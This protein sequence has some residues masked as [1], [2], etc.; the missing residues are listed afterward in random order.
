MIQIIGLEKIPII[1]QKDNLVKIILSSLEQ[2]KLKIQDKDI[3]I[4]AQTIISR[5]E[6]RV[7]NLNDITPTQEASKIANSINNSKDPR[8]ITLI[9]KEAKAVLRTAVIEKVGKIIV[10]TNLGFICADAGI[11]ASNTPNNAVSLLPLDPDKSAA[12]IRAQ[13]FQETGRDAAIIISD[14]HGRPFRRGAI[15]VAIGV[16]GIKE[17]QDYRGQTDLFG[18]QLQ[19][20][21]I[22]IAD[23]LASAAELI[24]GEADEG[25]PIILIRGYDYEVRD[26]SA[27]RLIRPKE[28]DLFR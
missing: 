27:Q 21:I 14:T 3:L 1:K 10:E 20:T 9:L 4:I 12:E 19:K 22:A 11:D 8:L 28:Q 13:I 25:M 2:M 17:I 18:Y 7:R 23:E 16:A 24:M 15:N 26:G 6:G 5:I